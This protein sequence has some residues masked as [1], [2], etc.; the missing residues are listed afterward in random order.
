[1]TSPIRR[2]AVVS[3]LALTL[4]LPGTAS[5]AYAPY[6]TYVLKAACTNSGALYGHGKVVL[7]VQA[8]SYG[9]AGTNYF[10]FKSRLQEKIGGTWVTVNKTVVKSDVFPDNEGL[11][12]WSNRMR[13]FFPSA[14]H[15]RTRI[16]MQVQFWDQRAS[17]DVLL[18]K[19][20]H[21]TAGC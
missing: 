3:G 21:R 12:S 2:I 14:V 17:G 13:Y 11:F 8:H 6:R 16:I 1:M 20:G 5:A 9:D 7:K 19:Q 15:P 10:L 18:A 4:L